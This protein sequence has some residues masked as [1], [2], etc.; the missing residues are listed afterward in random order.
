MNLEEN[1][2]DWRNEI[3][4]QRQVIKNAIRRATPQNDEL[5]T[6]LNIQDTILK[7]LFWLL[8]KNT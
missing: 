7:G 5:I 6:L 3:A 2:P 1:W 8:E 4:T